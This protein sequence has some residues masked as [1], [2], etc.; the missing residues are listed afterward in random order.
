MI[1]LPF[2]KILVRIGKYYHISTD[3]SFS[4]AL[5][6]ASVNP[7]YDKRLF[8]EFPKKYKFR[9]CSDLVL[10][11]NTLVICALNYLFLIHS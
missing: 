10:Y 3:K 6:L 4:E 5:I 1:P 11:T 9:T 8:I 7:Q 2:P